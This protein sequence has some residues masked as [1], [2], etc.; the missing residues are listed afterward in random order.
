MCLFFISNILKHFFSVNKPFT[1][2]NSPLLFNKFSKISSSIYTN[3]PQFLPFIQLAEKWRKSSIK[4]AIFVL[5][6]IYSFHI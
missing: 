4:I 6:N 1:A 3:F 2:D 5:I